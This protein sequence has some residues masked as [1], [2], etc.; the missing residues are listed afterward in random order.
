MIHRYILWF[1]LPLLLQPLA[2][3]GQQG[4]SRQAYIRQVRRAIEN[5]DFT[6]RV[7]QAFPMV[8][9]PVHLDPGYE[10]RVRPDSLW[11][12]LPYFGRVYLAPMNPPGEGSI[13]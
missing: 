6:I 13:Y 12:H 9:G 7:N 11:V 1:A 8:H 3:R 2:S 4:R 5:R 10:L